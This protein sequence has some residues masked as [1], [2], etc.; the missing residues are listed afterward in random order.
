MLNVLSN[1]WVMSIIFFVF[2]AIISF[3]IGAYYADNARFPILDKKYFKIGSYTC[4]ANARSKPQK[5]VE[6]DLT[7]IRP[8]P[9]SAPKAIMKILWTDAGGGKHAWAY[10]GWAIRNEGFSLIRLNVSSAKPYLD[11][12]ERDDFAATPLNQDTTLLLFSNE[13]ETMS[14]RPGVMMGLDEA[15]NCYGSLV[16]LVPVGS[17]IKTDEL[18]AMKARLGNLDYLA[19][20]DQVSQILKGGFQP[21]R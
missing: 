9:L 1:P 12:R 15:N 10:K 2:G 3:I 17:H 5:I 8:R 19:L 7:V 16:L 6:W 13:T 20:K 4:Y 21:I 18:E 11:P 14:V